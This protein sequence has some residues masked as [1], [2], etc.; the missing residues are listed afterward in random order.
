M[1]E[2]RNQAVSEGHSSRYLATIAHLEHCITAFGRR[3]GDA[4]AINKTHHVEA[5]RTSVTL[6]A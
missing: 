3:S 4:I 2:S 1:S 6:A 5:R